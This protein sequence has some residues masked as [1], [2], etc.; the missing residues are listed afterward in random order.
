MEYLPGG[1]LLDRIRREGRLPPSEVRTY[2]RGLAD[3]LGAAMQQG[4]LHRDV[5]PGNVFNNGIKLAD[6]GLAK[7]PPTR[8]EE[9]IPG[10]TTPKAAI[11]GTPPYVAP[12]RASFQSG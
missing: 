1:T 6:F 10:A 5:K 8:A 7:V 11:V 2:F 12:E 3:A 9:G 4:I